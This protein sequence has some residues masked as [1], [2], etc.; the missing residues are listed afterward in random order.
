[1]ANTHSL[2]LD[3]DLSQYATI[4][5]GDQ[6][7]L[8]L[9]GDFTMEG[10]FKFES[11]PAIHSTFIGKYAASGS[12]SY[13]LTLFNDGGTHKLRAI[14]SDNGSSVT[15]TAHV[16]TAGNFTFGVWYHIAA[17]YDA[18]A[19]TID[20]YINGSFDAQH[21]GQK[22]S[23]F[24]SIAPFDIGMDRNTAGNP[25][26]FFDG[27]IDE[28]RMWSDKRTAQE[29]A[30][31]YQQELVGDE[32]GL[33]GY[34]KFNDNYLDETPNNNDLTPSGSPVFSTDVPFGVILSVSGVVKLSG[35]VV[36][37]ATVRIV[38]STIGEYIATALSDVNGLFAFSSLEDSLFHVFV[39]F[40]DTAGNF[41]PADTKYN[42]RSLW[43][44]EP[45]AV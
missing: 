8:D 18:S 15:F 32:A 25:I 2:N 7:G 27:K 24:N 29:I 43:A 20:W 22:T 12:R 35:V 16:P 14:F 6:T 19:G 23:L 36:E 38:D 3:K 30:D 41:G 5:D 42:A 31:N 26:R 17:V 39:E 28:I 10:W 9:T 40:E 21:T 37:G 4:T 11:T 44:I 33:V 1:M 45:V 13:I 34:W